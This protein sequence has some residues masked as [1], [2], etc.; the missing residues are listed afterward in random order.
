MLR[1]TAYAIVNNAFKQFMDQS[2]PELMFNKLCSP[3]TKRALEALLVYQ[4]NWQKRLFNWSKLLISHEVE[5]VT[6]P[7]IYNHCVRDNYVKDPSADIYTLFHVMDRF[8]QDNRLESILMILKS[9]SK[10]ELIELVYLY[11]ENKLPPSVKRPEIVPLLSSEYLELLSKNA[12][13]SFNEKSLITAK[14]LAKRRI[15]KYKSSYYVGTD[16]TKAQKTNL[17]QRSYDLTNANFEYGD[18]VE[19]CYN[20]VIN[21]FSVD[22]CEYAVTTNTRFRR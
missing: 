18:E 8:N 7:A 17:H 5:V 19:T 1:K 9:Y 13:L 12:K 4:L 10:E 21:L 2:T 14:L 22:R 3:K 20:R 15:Y 6:I 16:T 11:R